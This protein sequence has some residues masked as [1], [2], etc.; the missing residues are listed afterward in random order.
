MRSY[1]SIFRNKIKKG[2]ITPIIGVYDAL[3]ATLSNQY[4]DSLF[5]SGY[6]FSASR[7]GLP[8]EGFIAW[9]D[10]IE[11]VQN[12]RTILPESNIIVDIDDGYGDDKIAS[13]AISSLENVGASAV[14]L[15]DQ[16]RPKKCGHLPGKEIIDRSEYLKKVKYYT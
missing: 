7:Y 8:D 4:F 15:E 3:S 5:C 1:G 13:M 9:K 6:G 10:M 14:I 11:Y 12:M 2:E 16:R